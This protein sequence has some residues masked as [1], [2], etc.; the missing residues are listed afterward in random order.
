MIDN[1]VTLKVGGAAGEGV[2]TVGELFAMAMK[3]HG[4][5]VFYH[6]DYPSLIK[7]GHNWAH[8]TASEKELNAQVKR[9]DIVVALNR[10]CIDEH[11]AEISKG[12]ALIHDPGRTYTS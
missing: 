3:R 8:V 5:N 12:G 11:L 10:R 7:G 6:N 9:V 4:L 2:F 1:E